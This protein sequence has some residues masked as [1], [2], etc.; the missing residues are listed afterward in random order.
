MQFNV[1]CNSSSR[2]KNGWVVSLV[3]WC[4]THAFM[5]KFIGEMLVVMLEMGRMVCL[6]MNIHSACRRY[7]GTDWLVACVRLYNA[8][9]YG[10]ENWKARLLCLTGRWSEWLQVIHKYKNTTARVQSILVDC[11]REIGNGWINLTILFYTGRKLVGSN[12]C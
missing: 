4:I 6:N 8:I 11:L 5:D 9:Q 12:H 10:S 7:C 3:Y 1:A 2:E